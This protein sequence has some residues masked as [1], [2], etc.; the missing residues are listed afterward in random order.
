MAG[1]I[2]L[3]IWQVALYS[4]GLFN[5]FFY[6]AITVSSGTF[7]QRTSERD[8]NEFLLGNEKS[9]HFLTDSR[10]T[11]LLQLGTSTGT[12]PRPSSTFITASSSSET[13]FSS[14]T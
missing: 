6:L 11:N 13:S 7:F 14:I 9:L 5:Y 2:G 4:F 8:R 1:I 10:L 12:F 3:L